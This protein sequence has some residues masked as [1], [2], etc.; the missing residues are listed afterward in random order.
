MEQLEK[1]LLELTDHP[2]S[3]HWDIALEFRDPS[4]YRRE[5]FDI[6]R[7]H[8]IEMVLH[9]MPRS[10]PPFTTHHAQ[11]AYL[12]FHGPA[13]DYRGGYDDATLARYAAQIKEWVNGG[14]RVYTYFNNTVGDAVRNLEK[15]NILVGER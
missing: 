11:F 2:E 3:R 9:D 12:R 14:L 10:M 6:L 13:G 5:T 7:H 4:W 1:L 15:L 8:G